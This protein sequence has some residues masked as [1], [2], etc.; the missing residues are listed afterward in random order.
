MKTGAR[1]LNQAEPQKSDTPPAAAA[2]EGEPPEIGIEDFAKVVLKTGRV[3]A[4]APHPNA[5][6]LLVLTVDVGGTERTICAGIRQWVKPEDMLD[7]DIVIVANLK[8]RK[9]R[10]I[11]SQ[12]M[13]L[14]V[15]DGSDVIP[16]TAMKRVSSG[17]RVS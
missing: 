1:A 4:A 9:M 12:G 11:D 5:D 6:K 16:L 15:T 14:A 7:K 2:A 13:M 17:L 8:P 10:G 3:K